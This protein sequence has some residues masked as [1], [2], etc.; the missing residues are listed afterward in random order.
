MSLLWLVLNPKHVFFLFRLP[1]TYSLGEGQFEKLKDGKNQARRGN[2]SDCGN[3]KECVDRKGYCLKVA[4]F[5]VGFGRDREYL[6]PLLTLGEK[7]SFP[8]IFEPKN[9][10]SPNFFS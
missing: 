7:H 5:M 1:F 4:D 10:F 3:E 8:L 9:I 2:S 6:M